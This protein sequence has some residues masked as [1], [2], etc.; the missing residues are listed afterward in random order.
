MYDT[1]RT[2]VIQK[3]LNPKWKPFLIPLN[4]LCSVD[5]ER[6]IKVLTLCF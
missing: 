5:F 1:F 6:Q 3:T 4:S 2:E